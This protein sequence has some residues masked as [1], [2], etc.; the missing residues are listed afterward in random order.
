MALRADDVD[1]G[2]D[3]LLVEQF[4]AGDVAGFEDLYRR[5]Y[6]RLYRFCLKRV[7]DS[8]EAEEVTQEAFA[9]AYTAMPRLAG[10][11]KFYPWI[12]VIAAR[13]CLDTH[14]RRARSVPLPELDLGAIDGDQEAIVL[15]AA[16]RE[17]LRA[18]MERLG[19]RHREVLRL[20]EQE[21][22][23]YQRI[24]EYYDVSL[25]TVEQ[26]LW[27]SRRALRREFE[28]VAGHDAR[29]L[30]GLPVIG[31]LMRRMGDLRAR[32]SGWS[33]H[34]IAPLATN[35][36]S[37]V[38]VV[39]SAAV[40][41]SAG[42]HSPAAVP[43]V[44]MSRPGAV[45]IADATPA[46]AAAIGAAASTTSSGASSQT[47]AGSVSSATPV[48]PG[49]ISTDDAAAGRERTDDDPMKVD[50]AGVRVAGRPADAVAQ[51]QDFLGQVTP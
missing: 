2:R 16:D 17:M 45:R 25:G 3:R 11:R 6:S 13:L 48:V 43:H 46:G 28:A 22:W 19:P 9:R 26:L 29:A 14:R 1:L 18:A 50:V 32:V 31:W 8:A 4:Q 38:M 39:T 42:G 30:A 51:L 24:A 36:V 33:E 27:R 44:Q 21:G 23:S 49:V 10:E 5:Y 15:Q 34:V 40:L 41:A 37:M 47:A 20:R 12:S 35:A 7:G